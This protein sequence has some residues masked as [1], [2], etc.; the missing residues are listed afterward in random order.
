MFLA[1]VGIILVLQILLITFTGI[2][3]NVY[4]NFGLHPLQWLMTI[5]IGSVGLLISVILKFIPIKNDHL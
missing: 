4:S 1:I 2:A 3:F 5:A